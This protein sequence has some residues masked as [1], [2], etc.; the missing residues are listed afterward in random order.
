MSVKFLK[1]YFLTPIDLGLTMKSYEN[2]KT[3]VNT[4]VFVSRRN[5]QQIEPID[6]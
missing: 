3:S 5:E 4:E 1:N 6:R 2:K